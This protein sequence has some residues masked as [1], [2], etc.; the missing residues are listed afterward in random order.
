MLKLN[1]L[2][3]IDL[4]THTYSILTMILANKCKLLNETHGE[5]KKNR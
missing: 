2:K 3:L 1:K 4:T 5:S